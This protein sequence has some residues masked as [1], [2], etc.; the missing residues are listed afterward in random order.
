M[1]RRY[2]Y[3]EK[4]FEEEIKKVCLINNFYFFL[5]RETSL[6]DNGTLCGEVKTRHSGRTSVWDDD[7]CLPKLT[8]FVRADSLTVI[9]TMCF[10]AW[11]KKHRLICSL[12]LFLVHIWKH[13]K[14]IT[15]LWLNV[16]IIWSI[17]WW[18]IHVIGSQIPKVYIWIV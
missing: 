1:I 7:G 13:G 8:A 14:F 10:Q 4:G 16:L 3:L 9:Q 11:L 18:K 2:K 17:K 12:D 15:V 6:W 5:W